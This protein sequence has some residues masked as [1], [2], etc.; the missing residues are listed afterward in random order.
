[1][2]VKAVL[3]VIAVGLIG[4]VAGVGFGTWEAVCRDCPSVAQ[5]YTWEP[6][7]ST[8]IYSQDGEMIAEFL[9]E[10]RT[11]IEIGTLPKYVPQ[12]FIAVE[13]KRF[14]KHGGL[15]YRRIIGAAARNAMHFQITG[16]GSTITQQLARNMFPQEIG[17]RKRLARK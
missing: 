8:K 4:V 9:Q 6:K 10:R 13:D 7:S 12:A 15:D 1:M 5:I 2:S 16:G 11:P 17:F 14:Y 3:L